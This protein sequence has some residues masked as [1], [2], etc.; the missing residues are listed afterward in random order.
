VDEEALQVAL[1]IT[2]TRSNEVPASENE[3]AVRSEELRRCRLE[4]A[5]WLR[6]NNQP[7]EAEA[8]CWMAWQQ[9]RPRIDRAGNYCWRARHDRHSR[10]PLA[11]R[12][13][14]S[15][16]LDELPIF[17]NRRTAEQALADGLAAAYAA[18]WRD[19]MDDRR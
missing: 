14:M 6:E 12:R 16:E 11:V 2:V 18:G 9:L 5:A 13:R 3:R 19:P 7:E 15:G 10:L 17:P 1:D 4:L 8:Q